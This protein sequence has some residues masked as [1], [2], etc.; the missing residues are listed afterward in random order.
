MG[1]TSAGLVRVRAAVT[2]ARFAFMLLRS[3]NLP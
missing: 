3:A 1:K 2:A